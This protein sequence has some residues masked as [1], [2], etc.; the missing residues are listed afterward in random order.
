MG[1][2]AVCAAGD[3]RA[4]GVIGSSDS[5][6]PD[7]LALDVAPA[8]ALEDPHHYELSALAAYTTAP[9]R[10]A[11]NPFGTGFG[12]RFGLVF[13]HV[14]FGGIVADYL[15]GTDVDTSETAL[16]FGGELGYDVATPLAGGWLTLRPQAGLGL[17]TI[18]RTDPSL[19]TAGSATATRSASL[20]KPDVITQATSSSA[21]SSSSSTGSS[22]SSSG[23]SD[24]ITL[25]NVYLQPGVTL[26]YG[27]GVTFAGLNANLLVV[28]GI[29]YSDSTSTWV[30]YGFEGRFGFRW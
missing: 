12:A 1:A 28:P 11:T 9:I 23:P 26:L 30:S 2:L 17:V 8:A 18:T 27:S 24:K 5:P 22:S 7:A 3:A 20:R 25:S 21:G 16:L 4:D 6:S 13:S 29:H 14:Y 15:G 19:L 10:G